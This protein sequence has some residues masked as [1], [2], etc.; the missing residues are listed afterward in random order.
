MRSILWAEMTSSPLMYLLSNGWLTM[1]YSLQKE[2]A[3]IA[4]CFNAVFIAFL[5]VWCCY[6]C[7]NIRTQNYIK[8]FNNTQ[9]LS[10]FLK[11]ILST[12]TNNAYIGIKIW[13]FLAFSLLALLLIILCAICF[14][15]KDFWGSKAIFT[16]WIV[17]LYIIGFILLKINNLEN[18]IFAL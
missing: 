6:W 9:M 2:Y 11:N 10:I 8:C 18:K 5:I 14:K 12:F 15:I 4:R 13:R 3:D 1:P 17:A 16:F 7:V